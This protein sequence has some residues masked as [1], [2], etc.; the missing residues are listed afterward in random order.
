VRS[1]STSLLSKKGI[2]ASGQGKTLLF[3]NADPADLAI[4][5]I[6]ARYT[7]MWLVCLT[8]TDGRVGALRSDFLGYRRAG[9]P[10]ESTS[11]LAG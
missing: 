3:L 6:Y 7:A 2:F 5:I 8:G 9:V 1:F 10:E 11:G 4:L